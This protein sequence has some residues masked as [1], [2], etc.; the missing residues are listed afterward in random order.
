MKAVNQLKMIA[1]MALITIGANWSDES[2]SFAK[3]QGI[4]AV[5]RAGE[6]KTDKATKWFAIRATQ[7]AR[8]KVTNLSDGNRDDPFFRLE[9]CFVDRKGKVISQKVHI[10]DREAS[11]VLEL[12]GSDLLSGGSSNTQLRAI[13]RFVGTPDTRIADRYVA[14]LEVFDN[15]SG[16]TRFSLPVAPKVQKAQTSTSSERQ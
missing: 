3:S 13:V 6:G 16:E 2:A 11:G 9:L 5:V 12:K 4:A 10:L 8:L 14:T 15:Q 7:T 1:L